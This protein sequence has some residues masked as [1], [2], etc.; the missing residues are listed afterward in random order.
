MKE[1][2]GE[3]L[4][5]HTGLESCAHSCKAGREALTGVH[6]GGVL[7]REIFI[8]QSADDVHRDGRQHRWMRNCEHPLDSARSKTP[9]CLETSRARTGRPHQRPTRSSERAGWR[10]R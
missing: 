9:A 2:Y 1:P 8:N 10:R 5:S 6:A 7:S 4:A 3:G